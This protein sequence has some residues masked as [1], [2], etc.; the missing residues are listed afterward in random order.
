MNVDQKTGV[1][2]LVVS[3]IIG[4][5]LGSTAGLWIGLGFVAIGTVV[6]IA[7]SAWRGHG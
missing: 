7:M 1:T 6:G 4:V 2:R 3:A 5:V